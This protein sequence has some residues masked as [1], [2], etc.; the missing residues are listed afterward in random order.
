MGK[1]SIANSTSVLLKFS[2]LLEAESY[3]QVAY[4]EYRDKQQPYF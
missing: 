2:S 4:L 1:L 3:N